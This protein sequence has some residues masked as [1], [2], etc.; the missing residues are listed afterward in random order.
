[1]GAM[2][3]A[4]ALDRGIPPGISTHLLIFPGVTASV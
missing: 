4:S 3:L 2:L 1:M